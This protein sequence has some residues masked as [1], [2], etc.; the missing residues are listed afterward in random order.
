MS[1]GENYRFVIT[2]GPGS[3]KSSL[4]CELA[5]SGFIVYPDIA[6]H[7]MEEGMEAPIN[8]EQ[9][10]S[11]GQF[12][13]IVLEERIQQ[14]M[15]GEGSGICFYDRAIPDNLGFSTYLDLPPSKQLLKALSDYNYNRNVFILPPWKSI[16]VRDK[17]RLEN[18]QTA[19]EIYEC[20]KTAYVDYGYNPIEVPKMPIE[21]R[22]GFILDILRNMRLLSD[23]PVG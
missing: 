12:S 17:I 6:R 2:G 8:M 19:S 14:H 23:E 10:S 22:L 13:R 15:A 18:F 4:V 7:L 21:K 3:G 20:I 11:S 9:P 5:K 16:Y 1:E